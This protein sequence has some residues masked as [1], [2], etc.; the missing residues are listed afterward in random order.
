MSVTL[1]HTLCYAK[2]FFYVVD[3][4]PKVFFYVIDRGGVAQSENPGL[5]SQGSHYPIS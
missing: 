4:S 3:R 5:Y 1:W 2:V